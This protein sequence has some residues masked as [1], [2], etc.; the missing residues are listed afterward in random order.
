M[1]KN[2]AQYEGLKAHEDKHVKT[3]CKDSLCFP[4]GSVLAMQCLKCWP[5]TYGITEVANSCDHKGGSYIIR[6]MK[7][8]T[9]IIWN[10]RYI[11][12]TPVSTGQYLWEQI[13]RGLNN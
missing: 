13:K 3:N 10:M 8:G 4:M 11:C 7:K 2:D 9:L 5:L 12:S 6:L 1:N